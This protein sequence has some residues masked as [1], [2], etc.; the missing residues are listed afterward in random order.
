MRKVL[1]SIEGSFEYGRNLMRGVGKYSHL[2]GPWM[3]YTEPPRYRKSRRGRSIESWIKKWSID[4]IIIHLPNAHKDQEIFNMGLPIIVATSTDKDLSGFHHIR[5]DDASIGKI[6]AKHYFDR[7]FRNYAYCG[8]N[9]M[10]WSQDRGESFRKEVVES[11]FE[12][13]MYKQ[14]LSRVVISW[15]KEQSHMIE[16]L[17]SL[18]KPVG[19][20]TCNDDRAQ[21]VIEACWNANFRIPEDVAILGVDNDIL[22]CELLTP[23]LSSVAVNC[24]RAGYQ[25]AELLDKLMNGQKIS[26]QKIVIQPT[27]VEARQSTDILTIEDQEVAKAVQFIFQRAKKGIRVDD[28]V[29]AVALSRRVLEKRFRA[30]LGRSVHDEIR[31][32]RIDLASRM[33]KETNMSVSQIAEAL[34][35]L[36]VRDLSRTFRKEKGVSPLAYRKKNNVK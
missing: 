1:V 15:D 16:W 3:V 17:K 29:Q 10:F 34:E 25:A 14:P 19:L 12:I 9:D 26:P 13:Q 11:G 33:L 30:S 32:V 31:R 21:H 28:V 35:F 24:E 36:E 6:G 18:P 5:P 8:F 22:V 2:H 23:Q 7:G 20:M 4:G 27:H